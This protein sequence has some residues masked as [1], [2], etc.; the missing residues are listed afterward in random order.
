MLSCSCTK[1]SGTRTAL[2]PHTQ[3]FQTRLTTPDR[4]CIQSLVF[5]D[6]QRP[7]HSAQQS[8]P[9]THSHWHTHSHVR[10]PV[11]PAVPA[12]EAQ[13]TGSSWDCWAPLLLTERRKERRT[14]VEGGVREGGEKECVCG[15]GREG[16][17][18]RGR[19]G[20]LSA[21]GSIITN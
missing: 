10:Q 14:G 2:H 3:K 6:P 12:A 8:H 21:A 13:Q 9:H 15:G 16:G 18:K 4:S 11:G 19:S 5:V 20:L 17:S 1:H 7:H